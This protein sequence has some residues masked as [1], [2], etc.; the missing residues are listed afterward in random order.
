MFIITPRQRPTHGL[1]GAPWE[2]LK[3]PATGATTL[4]RPFGSF[5]FF[6]EGRGDPLL[7]LPGRG[8]VPVY[9]RSEG[10]VGNLARPRVVTL[11]A[12]PRASG[13]RPPNVAGGAAGGIRPAAVANLR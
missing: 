5:S 3:Q 6:G 12:G 7:V 8:P 9:W 2:D 1:L 4:H 10:S 11:R 13:N